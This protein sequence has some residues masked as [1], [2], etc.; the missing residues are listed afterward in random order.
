MYKAFIFII[1][2]ICI[3]IRVRIQI[4]FLF[5]ER[6]SYNCSPSN[7]QKEYVLPVMFFFTSNTWWSFMAWSTSTIIRTI[8]FWIGWRRTTV[9]SFRWSWSTSTTSSI[10]VVGRRSWISAIASTAMTVTIS[11]LLEKTAYL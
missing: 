8:S 7:F 3:Y 2:A 9:T 4:I 5:K 1:D 11:C 10:M 6:G